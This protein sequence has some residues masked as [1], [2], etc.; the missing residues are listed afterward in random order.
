[1]RKGETILEITGNRR[2]KELYDLFMRSGY[3]KCIIQC[4]SKP[5][6][7]TA[8]V[9]AW[10]YKRDVDPDLKFSKDRDTLMLLTGR[11]TARLPNASLYALV[12]N[13]Q[14]IHIFHEMEG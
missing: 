7:E 3:G 6:A 14:E 4:R 11:K 9:R 12:V 13:K 1:M 5:E 2:W 10:V 8:R